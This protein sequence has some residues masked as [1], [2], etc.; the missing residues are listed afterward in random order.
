MTIKFVKKTEI[1]GKVWL[2]I[3]ADNTCLASF[4]ENQREEAKQY[5][6]K[7]LENAENG[8]A[9]SEVIAEQTFPD[10]TNPS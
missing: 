6:L 1:S 3:W 5:Y 9:T 7:C 4:Q 2:H 8:G 10:K